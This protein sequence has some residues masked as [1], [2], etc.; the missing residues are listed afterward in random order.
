MSRKNFK[1]RKWHTK[2]FAFDVFKNFKL[3]LIYLELNSDLGD[4]TYFYQNCR[5]YTQKSNETWNLKIRVKIKIKNLWLKG[6]RWKV[7]GSKSLYIQDLRIHGSSIGQNRF[8]FWSFNFWPRPD[9]YQ[10]TPKKCKKQ[11][12]FSLEREKRHVLT[13]QFL[14]SPVG[15]FFPRKLFCFKFGHL[16]QGEKGIKV[17]PKV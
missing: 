1:N 16:L 6:C 13:L 3:V 8:S 11:S 12:H 7:V 10:K 14:D 15:E 17:R 9:F 4:Q 5:S 2:S